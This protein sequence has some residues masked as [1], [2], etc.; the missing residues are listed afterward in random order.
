M[1]ASQFEGTKTTE[2]Y[3]AGV[4]EL[5]RK[6]DYHHNITSKAAPNDKSKQTRIFDRAPDIREMFIFR[7]SGCRSKP[8]EMF[9]QNVFSFKMIG[10]NKN[11]DAPDSL[12]MAAEMVLRPKIKAEVFKRLF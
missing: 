7:E 2:N 11:D 8:Y 10:K 12:A 3:K 1:Q 6:Y 5:L 4:E 9:M